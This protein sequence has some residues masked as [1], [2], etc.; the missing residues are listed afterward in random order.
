[1]MLKKGLLILA[2]VSVIT[3]CAT[4]AWS[5]PTTDPNNS[6]TRT[7]GL[8]LLVSDSAN[9]LNAQ[10]LQGADLRGKVAIF[11][12][13][14]RGVRS[15]AF[16]VDDPG[17]LTRPRQVEYYWP[18]DLAGTAGDGTAKLLDTSKLTTGR[19]VVTA[20]VVLTSGEKITSS[21][22][23]HKRGT[24]P[25]PTTAQPT[26]APQPIEQSTPSSSPST[27]T[28]R[29]APIPPPLTPTTTPSTSTSPT[30]TTA[31]VA[32]TA[33]A[34][35]PSATS[36]ATAAAT[37]SPGT[38]SS[39]RSCSG[40]P[41][42]SCTGVPAGTNLH[43]CPTTITSSGA[44]DA[45]S[46]SGDV[47]VKASNVKITRSQINGQVDAGSGRDGEQTG[48]II[49]DS[50]I[51]CNCLADDTH[52]PAAISESNYTLLRVNLYNSGHG[53]AV[54]SNVTIQDSYIHGLGANTEAHKD[55]IYS[56]DGDHV[57]IRH[58]NIECNDGS[59][60]GCTSAIG[61][62]VDFGRISYYTIENNLLNTNGSYCLYGGA[63]GPKPYSADHI[64]VLSN[65]FGRKNYSL[66][67]FYGP[68]TYFDS[69][70]PG[71]SWSGNVWDD[72]GEPVRAS[73]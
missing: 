7:R 15:V 14:P 35:T 8:R 56:G 60:A 10:K 59:K 55:G 68:V 70:A 52:T 30:A 1:M 26:T 40:F 48:L 20:Q 36:S 49:S 3:A 2:S 18:F 58:N 71:N 28:T 11:T 31:A 25:S 33:P 65:H 53:A 19:H 69:N 4:A 29:P 73:Y 46:F 44:Y 38:S 54:K 41:D 64:T 5:S 72:T 16:Y 6:T 50:T 66:C 12:N 51:N 24:A 67:G 27:S 37:Q 45:C 42:A 17:M 63:A 21:A 62:L 57:V 47:V 61:L 22:V 23:F 32:T 34:P 13:R 9:R 39:S 43:N